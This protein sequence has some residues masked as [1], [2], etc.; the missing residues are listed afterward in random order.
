MK[1]LVRK[2]MAKQM[3]KILATTWPAADRN[4][5]VAGLFNGVPLAYKVKS[6]TP[7][8]RAVAAAGSSQFTSPACCCYEGNDLSNWSVILCRRPKCNKRP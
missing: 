6:R 5:D 2:I 1:S 7:Q 3:Q 8:S 4:P